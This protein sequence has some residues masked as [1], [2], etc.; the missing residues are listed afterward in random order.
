MNKRTLGIEEHNI[1]LS[2]YTDDA[3]IVQA[4][5]EALKD[6][7][8]NIDNSLNNFYTSIKAWGDFLVTVSGYHDEEKRTQVIINIAAITEWGEFAYVRPE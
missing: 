4:I 7:D 3:L 5:N 2:S 1:L 6:M 8:I